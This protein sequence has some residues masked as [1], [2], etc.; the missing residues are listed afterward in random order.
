M[1]SISDLRRHEL[2]KATYEVVDLVGVRQLT[3]QR[4]A[5]HAGV[6]KGI[7]H[8]YFQNKD[9]LLFAAVRYANRIFAKHFLHLLAT[10]RSPTERLWTII[11][12]QLSEEFLTPNYLRPYL[13]VLEA[14][15]RN[16]KIRNI[17]SITDR[18][19]RSNLAFA[20][21]SLMDGQDVQSVA[22]TIWSFI[23]GAWLVLPGCP[24]VTRREILSTIREY[25]VDCVPGFDASIVSNFKTA[26][27]KSEPKTARVPTSTIRRM[28]LEQAALDI[29]YESGFRELTVQRAAEKAQLSKGVVHHYFLSKDDLVAGALRHEYRAFGLSV[30]GLLGK[31]NSPSERAWTII[32]AQLADPYLQLNS[33][34]WYLNSQEA[35]FRNPGIA[36]IYNIT[37]RRGRSNITFAL[38]QLTPSADA[39]R[40]TWSLWSMI[41][42]ACFLM[43]S[44]RA[45]KRK[46][47]LFGIAN[48]LTNSIPAF[49]PS[50]VIIDGARAYEADASSIE[51]E[52]IHKAVVEVMEHVS[53]R[54][55][56][57]ELVAEHLGIPV[58]AI[59]RHFQ[60]FGDLTA[61][62]IRYA[63]TAAAK[64]AERRRQQA[65]SASEALWALV[66]TE[67][68]PSFMVQRLAEIYV[69]LLEA[70]MEEREIL[71]TYEN[72]DEKSVSA[73]GSELR[74]LLP[75][76]AAEVVLANLRA[77]IDGAWRLLPGDPGTT[78]RAI[79]ATISE[80]LANAVPNF[81]VSV[82]KL[83]DQWSEESGASVHP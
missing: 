32:T 29:L 13:S 3:I 70:G 78:Q 56:T 25:L 80:Y 47:V 11:D 55:L 52:K 37:E 69:S 63:T 43:F 76:D 19:G 34:R 41:E 81:D 74:R 38:K 79:I 62:T 35:G 65:N 58:D 8:H 20:L 23:E 31:T 2:E 49:D 64:N 77:M 30:T 15:F 82:F 75:G 46:D 1:R 6:S 39:R 40:M 22:A 33:L 54:K 7:A 42:G 61:A 26:G 5:A 71:D 17:Y 83:S 72:V 10:I 67:V 60:S 24:G 28:E 16:K 9:E 73:I 68:E 27:P 53:Y 59:H 14:G 51:R 57:F 36:R 45:I 12:T 48:Y 21:R 4:V 44:D 18:R 66:Y 50:V